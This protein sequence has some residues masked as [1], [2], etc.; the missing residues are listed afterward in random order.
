MPVVTSTTPTTTTTATITLTCTASVSPSAA[1]AAAAALQL[2]SM[3]SHFVYVDTNNVYTDASRSTL[4]ADGVAYTALNLTESVTGAHLTWLPIGPRRTFLSPAFGFSHDRTAPIFKNPL[5]DVPHVFIPN[6]LDSVFNSSGTFANQASPNTS[7][8]LFRHRR[9]IVDEGGI[10]MGLQARDRGYNQ[11]EIGNF[12]GATELAANSGIAPFDVWSLL[13][14]EDN[15]SQSR[16]YLNGAKLGADVTLPASLVNRLY[17]G[18]NSHVLEHDLKFA[19]HFNGIFTAAQRDNLLAL[20]NRIVPIGSLPKAPVVTNPVVV[21]DGTD[22]FRVASYSYSAPDG[23][24]INPASLEIEWFV[25]SLNVP[26]V[27]GWFGLDGQRF[28]HRGP[29]LKRSLFPSSFP[30]P[31]NDQQQVVA[32]VRARDVNGCGWSG[33]PF[34]SRPLRDEIP[35]TPDSVKAPVLAS[36]VVSATATQRIALTWSGGAALASSSGSKSDFTVLVNGAPAAVSS[37]A[38]PGGSVLH[39]Q[40]AAPLAH[41]D[42]IT[43][44]LQQ[45]SNPLKDSN[46]KAVENFVTGI[47]VAVVNQIP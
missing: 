19:G 37:I 6:V 33:V 5:G 34:R 4:A 10:G 25:T 45:G 2:K 9:A 11:Y 29:T 41:A 32:V 17:Y 3:F 22:T 27:Q 39:L 13:V 47:L 20:A 16:I 36:A 44:K 40:L 38:F 21:F 7:V 18:T 26:T 24:A 42:A 8:V 12:T 46:N 28:V 14:L 31:G 35:G 43:V 15:G 30:I 1:D 23:A